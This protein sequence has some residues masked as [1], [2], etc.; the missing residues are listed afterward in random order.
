[1]LNKLLP[2]LLVITFFGCSDSQENGSAT[3]RER[4]E[5]IIE[6]RIALREGPYKPEDEIGSGNFTV[7][8]HHVIPVILGEPAHVISRSGNVVIEVEW[9]DVVV[10]HAKSLSD[11]SLLFKIFYFHLVNDLIAPNGDR[12]GWILEDRVNIG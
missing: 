12:R 5:T 6:F 9:D 8:N 7:L 3:D 11:S 10:K 2:F 4:E 1:M